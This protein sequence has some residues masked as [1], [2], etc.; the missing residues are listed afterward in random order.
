MSKIHGRY[1]G[2]LREFGAGY[3]LNAVHDLWVRMQN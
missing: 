1:I 3:E 2:A